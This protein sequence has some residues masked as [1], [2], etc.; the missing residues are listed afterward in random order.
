MKRGMCNGCDFITS[1]MKQYG[2]GAGTESP[3]CNK[4]MLHLDY[5]EAM[6][7]GNEICNLY[8]SG[9]VS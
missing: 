9:G 7:E 8:Q 2:D 6:K 3:Y 4:H 5:I 1:E